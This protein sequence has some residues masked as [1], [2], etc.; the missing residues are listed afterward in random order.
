MDSFGKTIVDK[1]QETL[2]NL[3]TKIGGDNIYETKRSKGNG[4]TDCV[5]EI[6]TLNSEDRYNNDS[7]EDIKRK[8]LDEI[9]ELE[10]ALNKNTS[11]ND[12]KILRTEFPD[13]WINLGEKLAYPYEYFNGINEC[14][15]PVNN[16]KKASVN[17]KTVVPVM[18]E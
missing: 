11:G 5:K 1:N 15:K 3:K 16:L 10:E 9:E 18:K 14:Q 7:V 13:E 12:L 2:E 17:Q 6:E 4:I 8:F